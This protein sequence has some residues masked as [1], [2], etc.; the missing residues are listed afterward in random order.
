MPIYPGIVAAASEEAAEPGATPAWGSAGTPTAAS[1]LA[2]T[3]SIAHPA[4][5]NVGDLLVCIAFGRNTDGDR[6]LAMHANM[7]NAGWANITGS[8]LIDGNN[9]ALIA[10]K[11]AVGTEA[12][13]NIPGGIVGSGG[14]T[15]NVFFGVCVRFTAADGFAA[16]PFESLAIA[17]ADGANVSSV[18]MP[19]VTPTGINRLAVS[20]LTL[21][22]DIAVSPAT[23]ESG[24]DWTEVL[25]IFTLVGADATIQV[26]VSDQSGGGAISGGT[27]A[28][29]GNTTGIHAKFAL[30]PADG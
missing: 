20:I 15:S 26:Q 30:V 13:T 24:G 17:A 6:N 12:G 27:T 23:G 10:W 14:A 5:V 29:D 4:T 2:A 8:P 1:T 18:N 21:F 11:E 3:H 28:L 7:V 16:N 19:T 25:E 9:V 22:N